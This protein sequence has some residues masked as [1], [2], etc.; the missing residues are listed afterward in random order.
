MGQPTHLCLSQFHNRLH[1]VNNELL[2]LTVIGYSLISA[3]VSVAEFY[4]NAM[5]LPCTVG[6]L[7]FRPVSVK[8]SSTIPMLFSHLKIVEPD[9]FSMDAVSTNVLMRFA[10]CVTKIGSSEYSKPR[11]ASCV[12]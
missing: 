7:L 9:S 2:R 4:G 5:A 11:S 6:R 8:I 10:I 12:I 1:I 3:V